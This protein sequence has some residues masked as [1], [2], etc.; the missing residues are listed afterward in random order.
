MKTPQIVMRS[1]TRNLIDV[2]HGIEGWTTWTRVQI[3][4]K[5]QEIILHPKK[6]AHLPQPVAQEVMNYVSSL[7]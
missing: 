1:V 3:E 2:F 4:R 6:G 7:S 5:R